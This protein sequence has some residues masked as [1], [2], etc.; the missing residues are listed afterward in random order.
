MANEV[1]SHLIF[2]SPISGK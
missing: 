1:I 2:F